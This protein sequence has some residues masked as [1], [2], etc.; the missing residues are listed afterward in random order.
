MPYTLH[1]HTLINNRRFSATKIQWACV[2][3]IEW[4]FDAKITA[5]LAYGTTIP[6]ASSSG[7]NLPDVQL[8]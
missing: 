4:E 2:M 7:R 5:G 8:P 1:A 6:V 3:K